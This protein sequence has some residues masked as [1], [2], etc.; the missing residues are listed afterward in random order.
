MATLSDLKE[1]RAFQTVEPIYNTIQASPYLAGKIKANCL[2]VSGIIVTWPHLVL[3]ILLMVMGCDKNDNNIPSGTYLTKVIYH[4]NADQIRHYCYNDQGFLASREFEFD[5]N[6]TEKFTYQYD[7]G[8]LIKIDSYGITSNTDLTLKHQ[9]YILF[10]YDIDDIKKATLYPGLITTA[11][12]YDNSRVRKIIHPDGYSVYQ[13]DS[14]GNIENAVLFKD[15]SE[16]WKFI[17]KY[18]NKKNP[19]YNVDPIHD[20]I[21]GVDLISYKCPN[22]LTY[23]LFINENNDTISESEFI[24]KYNP[25][26]YPALSYELYTSESNGYERDSMHTLI[27]EYEIK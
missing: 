8:K 1:T 20:N 2:P 10:D 3:I 25:D 6:I 17:Y 22:N 24:Y 19:F 4:Q 23:K 16:Y 11:Y 13:Y 14:R 21:S 26:E 5:D 9:G 15:G 18:D 27:Y 7:N 12:E